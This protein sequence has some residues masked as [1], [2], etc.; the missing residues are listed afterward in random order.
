MGQMKPAL[1]ARHAHETFL[2]D[3]CRRLGRKKSSLPPRLHPPGYAARDAVG[4]ERS[5]GFG[6]RCVER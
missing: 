3:A 1:I 6:A 5:H 2:M 4:V